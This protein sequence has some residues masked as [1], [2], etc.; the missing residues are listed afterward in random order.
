MIK[1]IKI[2]GGEGTS[3]TTYYFFGIPVYEIIYT[4]PN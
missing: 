3:R 1:K 2:I 4:L